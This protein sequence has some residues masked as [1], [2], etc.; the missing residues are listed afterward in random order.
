[1]SGRRATVPPLAQAGAGFFGKLP[2][3]G[4]FVGHGLSAPLVAVL[5]E[6][7]QLALAGSRSMLGSEWTACWLVAPVWHFALP[8]AMCGPSAVC[9]VLLPSVDRVGRYFPLVAAMEQRWIGAAAQ[10]ALEAAGRNA[11]EQEWTPEQL[12][13]ALAAVAPDASGPFGEPPPV[14]LWWTDGGP[15]V[16]PAWFE[17][18]ALPDPGRFASMLRA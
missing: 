6:W 14:G 7:L 5:E 11:L 8:R 13:S 18:V 16:M 4:D 1:M 17:A 3:R 10:A 12:V 15:H 2:A 9:G